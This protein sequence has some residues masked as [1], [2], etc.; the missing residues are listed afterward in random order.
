MTKITPEEDYLLTPPSSVEADIASAMRDAAPD[1][2]SGSPSSADEVERLCAALQDGVG[3]TPWNSPSW[4]QDGTD[5]ASRQNVRDAVKR[6]LAAQDRPLSDF[7]TKPAGSAVDRVHDQAD[8]LNHSVGDTIDAAA[9]K[10]FNAEYPDRKFE[11]ISDRA[12]ISW[13]RRAWEH[14]VNEAKASEYFLGRKL[15]TYDPNQG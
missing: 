13:M 12:K 5:G 7:E 3:C 8:Y 15:D 14:R 2:L 1:T 6:V 10:L 9:E 4:D 11:F